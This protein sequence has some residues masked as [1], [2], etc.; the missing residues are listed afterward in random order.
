MSAVWI[1]SNVVLGVTGLTPGAGSAAVAWQAL[2]C[3]FLAGIVLVGP[4]AVLA[5]R[6]RDHEIAP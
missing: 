4:V 6:G 5:G 1:G 2:I 3:G